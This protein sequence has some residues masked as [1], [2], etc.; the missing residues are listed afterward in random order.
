MLQNVA[1][2]YN[3]NK[4]KKVYNF[5][6]IATLSA[7]NR[8]QGALRFLPARFFSIRKRIFPKKKMGSRKQR[9][10]RRLSPEK[11]SNRLAAATKTYTRTAK[12]KK[13]IWWQKYGAPARLNKSLL[14]SSWAVK[15]RNTKILANRFKRRV[16]VVKIISRSIKL[17]P[18]QTWKK[19]ATFYLG[20]RQKKAQFS[21]S[22]RKMQ[23][24]R[25]KLALW[26]NTENIFGKIKKSVWWQLFLTN[27]KK[28]AS[29][30][31]KHRKNQ[32]FQKVSVQ[33]KVFLVRKNKAIISRSAWRKEIRNRRPRKPKAATKVRSKITQPRLNYI[34]LGKRW[35]RKLRF[36][37]YRRS[38]WKRFEHYRRFSLWRWN[39]LG[40]WASF[41]LYPYKIYRRIHQPFRFSKAK[42]LKKNKWFRLLN[43]GQEQGFAINR[44]VRLR[45]Q[46]LYTRLYSFFYGFSR[47]KQIAE[48]SRHFLRLKGST[49]HKR[50]IWLSWLERRL[51]VV[52]CRIRLAPTI[53][54]ARIL[55]TRGYIWVNKKQETNPHK[56]VALW[57][58]VEINRNNLAFLRYWYLRNRF[59]RHAFKYKGLGYRYFQ[60]QKAA[61]P[62]GFMVKNPFDL[63]VPKKDLTSVREVERL[64]LLR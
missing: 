3:S 59:Q 12:L 36:W 4:L 20:T 48:R 21:F 60:K 25:R 10:L 17:Q 14:V 9:R 24:R 39:N 40:K 19:K 62:F 38:R 27:W 54:V 6:K 33:K 44:Q 58:V 43:K 56:R 5:E 55:I 46:Q 50:N 51:D 31:T 13:F 37:K 53:N 64:F 32:K 34:K 15:A 2:K 16:D 63:D 47:P 61:L 45:N 30:S 1:Q 42:Q 7:G 23:T 57:D 22:S 8:S 28:K 11:R 29:L 41:Q 52:L 49:P 18:P 26:K 35:K